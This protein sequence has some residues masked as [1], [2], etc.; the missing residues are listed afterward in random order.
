MLPQG[1]PRK[2]HYPE[3]HVNTAIHSILQELPPNNLV[4]PA[5]PEPPVFPYNPNVLSL[6]AW[7]AGICFALYLLLQNVYVI[8]WA[9][10]L[11]A[12]SYLLIKMRFRFALDKYHA[13]RAYAAAYD[14][15]VAEYQKQLKVMFPADKLWEYRLALLQQFF[16][17]VRKPKTITSD[18]ERHITRGKHAIMFHTYLAECFGNAIQTDKKLDVLD[19]EKY[20][21]SYYPDFVYHDETGLFI[22]IEV[23][24]PYDEKHGKPMHCVGKDDDRNNFFVENRWA[25]IRFSEEQVIK[26]PELCCKEIALLVY[27]INKINYPV[28]DFT[29]TLPKQKKWTEYEAKALASKT[30]A[31]EY[32]A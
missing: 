16:G 4:A 7:V 27:S 26:W 6:Y 8:G 2:Y 18:D 32:A 20:N 19:G 5:P 1:V 25:V 31:Q 13:A 22:A 3:V 12:I 9:L 21:I 14:V 23:D 15:R 11:S 28:K 30:Y 17:A 24:E 29:G 10:A